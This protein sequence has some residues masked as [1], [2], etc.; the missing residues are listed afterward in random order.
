MYVLSKL[1]YYLNVLLTVRRSTTLVNDQLDAQ[2]FYFIMFI[3]V[4]YMF[5]ATSSSS[6]GGQIVLIQHLV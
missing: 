2:L 5:R 1:Q 3:T 6:S 4:L